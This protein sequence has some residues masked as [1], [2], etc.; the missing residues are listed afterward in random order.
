MSAEQKKTSKPQM[1]RR[2]L[3]NTAWGVALAA[4]FGESAGM[5]FKYIQPINTGGF[6]G[7]V[8]AGSVASFAPGSITLNKAGRFFLYR[9]ADGSFLALWQNAPI[10]DAACPGMRRKTS[11]TALAMVRSLLRKARCLAAR[12]RARW[13]FFL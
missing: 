3:L 6:G 5:L 1:S 12:P 11:F 10:W 7:V 9:L 4:L 2:Q 13:I 8:H